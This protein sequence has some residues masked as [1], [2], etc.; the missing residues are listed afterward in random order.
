MKKVDYEELKSALYP[1]VYLRS[2]D[3][4]EYSYEG[5]VK[6]KERPRMSKGGR[7]FTPPETR[8]FEASVA[9]WAKALDAPVVKYPVR[10][11]LV[12]YEPAPKGITTPLGDLFY[13]TKGD[14]DNLAKS[15][16]DGLNG[17][18]YLDDKQIVELHIRRCYGTPCGFDLEICRSG[19][20][21]L[22]YSNYC[23]RLK[24]DV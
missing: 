6:A 14:V 11:R 23:K 10:V 24:N 17:I 5:I 8:A 4:R 7:V 18:M 3:M 20:T 16:L 12:I 13:N 19:L 21:K 2:L 22:E 9:K 1:I 15:I